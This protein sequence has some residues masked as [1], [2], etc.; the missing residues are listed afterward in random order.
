MRF[1]GLAS[2]FISWRASLSLLSC[3]SGLS[4]VW[5]PPFFCPAK[6]EAFPF[7]L[8]PL[9]QSTPPFGQLFASFILP[10]PFRRIPFVAT[11]TRQTHLTLPLDGSVVTGH[12]D[13]TKGGPPAS[14]VSAQ[15]A[16]DI[17]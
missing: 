13:E 8:H 6:G 2:P 12:I 14:S 17:S 5:I 9:G 7:F 4:P 1:P 3:V 11:L 10:C 16:K 15:S